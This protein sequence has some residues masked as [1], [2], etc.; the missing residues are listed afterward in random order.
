M[1]LRESTYLRHRERPVFDAFQFDSF[2]ID[3]PNVLPVLSHRFG[4]AKKVLEGKAVSLKTERG[5]SISVPDLS[6]FFDVVSHSLLDDDAGF[7]LE[8]LAGNN[9]RRG[10]SLVREFLASGHTNAD[11]AIAAY[12][13]EGDYKFPRHEVFKGAVLGASKYFNDAL[14]PIPNVYDSKIGGYGVQLLR[15]Q[16]INQLVE[17]TN[18]RPSDGILFSD[19]AGP[20]GRVG[21][22]EHDLQ[23][24]IADLF[25]RGLIRTT[26]GLVPLVD[27]TVFAT[28]LA[29]YAL[30]QMC[31]EFTCA[32][33]CCL[34]S[35]ILDDGTW[36][37]LRE[38][39]GDIESTHSPAERVRRRV[40]R[41]GIFFEYVARSEER[42]IVECR[43]RD[44]P[45]SWLRPIVRDEIIPALKNNLDVAVRSA[46]RTFAREGIGRS[47]PGQ[48]AQSTA[49]ETLYG[50]IVSSW[51]DK[52]YVFIR[53][54]D[55]TEWFGH[56]NDFLLETEWPARERGRRCAFLRGE[57]K[58][59]P[60][61][62]AI[63]VEGAGGPT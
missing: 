23:S 35:V 56:R 49:P 38:I 17:S 27:S 44:L 11:R 61:A 3:P 47:L 36:D 48:R 6:R 54:D 55:S 25:N 9:V 8:C 57:W 14:S 2:Y 60:R 5:M 50:V 33:F 52:D 10:L 59:R 53:D 7:M 18:E 26:D 1:S 34:D 37:A 4:Y 40:D 15:L 51:P 62:V 21:V 22:N 63:R 45:T 46:A 19:L 43:R 29:G 32:E 39:T 30:R 28:R 13:N 42:W 16:L 20:L 41:V 58:G 31:R 24:V 12:L